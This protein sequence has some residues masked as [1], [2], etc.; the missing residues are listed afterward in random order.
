MSTSSVNSSIRCQQPLVL[1]RL[2]P[3]QVLLGHGVAEVVV[4]EP[5]VKVGQR[6]KLRR[7]LSPV[8]RRL[9]LFFDARLWGKGG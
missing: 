1:D 2:H 6:R 9:G 5:G 4:V 7:R 8:G 3:K